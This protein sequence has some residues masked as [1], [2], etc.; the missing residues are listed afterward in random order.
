MTDK[1]R[2]M[3]DIISIDNHLECFFTGR[4]VDMKNTTA[5]YRV[6]KIM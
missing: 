2:M 1:E 5:E 6:H 3:E 4:L